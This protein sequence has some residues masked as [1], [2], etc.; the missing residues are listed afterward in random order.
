MERR[1]TP[2]GS[3]LQ[4]AEFIH[5]YLDGFDAA[6]ELGCEV[7]NRGS[8][9]VFSYEQSRMFR[10]PGLPLIGW[11]W[12]VSDVLLTGERPGDPC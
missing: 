2:Y 3:G 7:F 10:G 1:D 8:R 11:L 9:F 5:F 12:F 6:A 4:E